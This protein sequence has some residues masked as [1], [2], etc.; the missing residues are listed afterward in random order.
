MQF[1]RQ[2]EANHG[3][4]QGSR[5]QIGGTHRQSH[6]HRQRREE[7]LGGTAQER[8]RNEDDADAKRGD[9]GRHGDLLRAIENRLDD[10]FAEADVAVDVFDLD[11]RIVNQNADRQRH[12]AQGHDVDRFPHRVQDRERRE[13]RER[14]RNANDQGAPPASEK[15]QDHQAG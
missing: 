14:N 9:E 11:G 10:P 5:E 4:D 3:R 13:N 15:K 2:Q 1:R 7:V 6:S 12:P 8:N